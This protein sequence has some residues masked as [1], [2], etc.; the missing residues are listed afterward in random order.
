M[1]YAQDSRVITTDTSEITSQAEI[2]A[3]SHQP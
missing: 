2:L 3:D 1:T